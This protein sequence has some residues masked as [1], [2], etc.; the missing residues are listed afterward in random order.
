MPLSEP[1][2]RTIKFVEATFGFSEF[3]CPP[4]EITD[5][6]GIQPDNVRVEGEIHRLK[7]GREITNAF[8]S[9]SIESSCQSKDI[10][11]HLRQLFERLQNVKLPFPEK[12][13]QPSFGIAWKSSNLYAG[14][15]PFYE[16][17]VI[18]GMARLQADLWQDIYAVDGD[19]DE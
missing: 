5:A 2:A 4:N 1:F 14:S 15:G 10:N 17:D 8:S 6:L 12:F 18:E 16:R 13:G 9:W 3:K 19:D 11:E 7:S